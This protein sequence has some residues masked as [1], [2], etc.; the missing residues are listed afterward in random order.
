[1]HT[2]WKLGL[3]ALASLGFEFS[4]ASVC[5]PRPPILSKQ[6]TT[7]DGSL[8]VGD[9]TSTRTWNHY[10]SIAPPTTSASESQESSAWGVIPGS[11]DQESLPPGEPTVLMSHGTVSSHATHETGSVSTGRSL[12]PIATSWDGGTTTKQLGTLPFPDT[13]MGASVPAVPSDGGTDVNTASLT[14]EANPSGTATVDHSSAAGHDSDTTPSL[15]PSESV[16]AL[17]NTSAL[18]TPILTHQS[19]C[20][21]AS[22]E[23]PSS[24]VDS[25]TRPVF[26]TVSTTSYQSQDTDGSNTKPADIQRTSFPTDSLIETDTS[27]LTGSGST[28][29]FP[30]S[31]THSFTTDAATFTGPVESQ[32]QTSPSSEGEIFI[33][34]SSDPA[35]TSPED[36]SLPPVFTV[37]SLS[38]DDD[39]QSSDVPALSDNSRLTL[40]V[41]TSNADEPASLSTSTSEKHITSRVSDEQ[42]HSDILETQAPIKTLPEEHTTTSAGVLTSPIEATILPADPKSTPSNDESLVTSTGFSKTQG[43][44]TTVTGTDGEIATWSAVR[45][46]DWSDVSQ[47]QTQTDDDGAIIVIFPG[48]WKWSPVGRGRK[49]GPTPTAVP[50]VEGNDQDDPDDN[51]DE[52][53]RC[54][55][56]SPPTCTMIM[57]YYTNDKGEGTRQVGIAH[58]SL[59]TTH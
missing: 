37:T 5:R 29:T 32:D 49:D 52:E 10:T 21:G 35:T 8:L 36:A 34:T 38:R 1:M 39:Q 9:A 6:P 58:Q 3:L 54:T 18:T 30:L 47:T 41:P 4:S 53:E 7:T 48:G 20:H 46:P 50:T 44:Q 16:T 55:S 24:P 12:R 11:R 51:D 56:T 43:Q 2:R 40:E 27:V 14:S 33:T 31:F 42:T 19:P 25:A 13:T 17:P 26:G 15:M 28:D 22:S 45:D 23:V 59:M 57:S